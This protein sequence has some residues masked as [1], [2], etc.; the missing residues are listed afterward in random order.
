MTTDNNHFLINVC[1]VCVNAAGEANLVFRQVQTTQ[2]LYDR[3][4][5]HEAAKFMLNWEGY[6]PV[7]TFD[8][9]SAAWKSMSLAS[10]KA[11]EHFHAKTFQTFQDVLVGNEAV[12]GADMVERLAEYLQESHVAGPDSGLSRLKLFVAV[13]SMGFVDPDMWPTD[14]VCVICVPEAVELARRKGATVVEVVLEDVGA[15]ANLPSFNDLQDAADAAIEAAAEKGLALT[16]Q[17][18]A[19]EVR[20]ALVTAGFGPTPESFN[21]ILAR[22][23]A[24]VQRAQ[25][26]T[27]R[28]RG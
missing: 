14:K 5:H 20:A 8:E 22:V 28:D 1:L 26:Q 15:S 11:G 6:R 3:G 12:S 10:N 19:E 23:I 13:S 17:N 4:E 7:L 2:D 27:E 25:Q 18:A 16:E 24:D 21:P 9:R